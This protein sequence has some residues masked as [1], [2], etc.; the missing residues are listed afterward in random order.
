MVKY[1]T[2]KKIDQFTSKY[3]FNLLKTIQFTS[4]INSQFYKNKDAVLIIDNNICDFDG[5]TFYDYSY[6]TSTQNNI[7]KKYKI[8]FYRFL[9]TTPIKE[10]EALIYGDIDQFQSYGTSKMNRAGDN[11]YLEALFEDAFSISYGPL[12]LSFLHKDYPILSIKGSTY[13][14]DYIVKLTNGRLI[15]FELNGVNYHHPQHVGLIQYT[16]QLE[17]QNL[18]NKAGIDIY[19]FSYDQCT[20]TS[21]NLSLLIKE[22][23]G[24]ISQ[25]KQ[26]TLLA[27]RNFTLY[28][29]QE[30]AIKELENL[31]IKDNSAMLIVLPTASG[32]T[33]IIIEDLSKYLSKNP[34][35]K[36]GIFAPTLA[37]KNNWI[38]TLGYNNLFHYD[39]CVGTYHLLTKLSRETPNSYFDYIIIDEAH[40]AVANCTKNA[41][42]HFKP[43][44]LVGLTATTQRLDNKRLEDVFGNYSTDLS[45]EEAMKKDIIAKARAYRIE[46][47]LD[48]SRVRYN[49]R[50]YNNGD[51]EK[52]IR[53]NSRNE[54]IGELLQQYFNDGS[55]GVVF[56]V[57]IDHAKEMAKILS[58]KF[59]FNAKAIS[60]KDGK[61]AEKILADFHNKKIQFLCVCDLLNEGWD[62]PEL[63]VLVMARPTLSKVLYM[64]Q[65]GRGLRKTPNKKEVYIIDV[66]DNFSYSFNP[67]STN[68]IFNN[69]NYVQW[70]YVNEQSYPYQTMICV[71]GIYE[72]VKNVVPININTLDKE[73]EGLLNIEA[74]ARKLF[75]GTNT[76][77]KWITKYNIKEDKI[78]TLGNNTLLYFNEESVEKIRIERGLPLHNDDTLKED[79]FNFLEEKNYT[80]SYKMIFLLGSIKLADCIGQIKLDELI[81]FYRD[82]YLTRIKNNLKVDKK[83]CIYDK[84]YLNDKSKVKTSILRNPF[85]KFERKRFLEYNKDLNKIAINHK[86][87]NQW[88]ENDKKKIVKI[89]K[90]HLKEY[91]SNI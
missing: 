32:K 49:N 44:L 64:Q 37:I 45:L 81:D 25:L 27:N 57:S 85:E 5:K 52:S 15:G 67:Y 7:T 20:N 71:N 14:I 24:D 40:H 61:K 51:L 47:N 10:I 26:K 86:L 19:R 12:T 90:Q 31:H 13:F 9:N 78:L 87:F 18:C 55:L 42:S 2:P 33:Q 65:L 16:K 89:M 59:N 66:V 1:N 6:Y 11:S 72:K 83:G 84:N 22:I 21:Y 43:K 58:A 63:K 39:I 82:F 73:I 38:K 41:L 62:E 76:F 4:E 50:E 54:L 30:G 77:K 29:H 75:I 79:F 17:K 28:D 68:A 70:G 36:V 53:V 3:N 23:V 8:P 34:K 69:P 60:S 91:Y 80:F 48:L 35:A 74:V 88:D 46:T 56:C